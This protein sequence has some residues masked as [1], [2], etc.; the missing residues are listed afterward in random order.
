MKGKPVTPFM[1][2]LPTIWLDFQYSPFTNT[3]VDDFG[4]LFIK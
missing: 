2:D 4:P 3:A 1:K